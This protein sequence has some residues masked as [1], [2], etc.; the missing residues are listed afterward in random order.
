MRHG[1]DWHHLRAFGKRPRDTVEYFVPLGNR[2]YIFFHS[3]ANFTSSGIGHCVT[4]D[5]CNFVSYDHLCEKAPVLVG[6]VVS[7]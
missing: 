6:F 7:T 5:T 4:W 1:K 3:C 2:L